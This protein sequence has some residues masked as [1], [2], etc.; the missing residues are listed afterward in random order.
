[1][2]LPHPN[3][4]EIPATEAKSYPHVWLYNIGVHAP[5]IDSG[6]IRIETLPCNVDTGEI[7]NGDYMVPLHTDKLWQA[8]AEV[9]E[10]AAAMEAIF[11]AVG[12]LAAWIAAQE[13]AAQQPEPEPE[14]APEPAK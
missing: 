7:A 1:M 12:P 13:T 3:P 11:A 5:S 14:P 8:V 10:V 9:P 6:S 4:V 2:P